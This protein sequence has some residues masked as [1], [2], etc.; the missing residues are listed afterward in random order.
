MLSALLTLHLIHSSLAQSVEHLTVNQGVAGSS[1]AGGAN[2]KHANRRAFFVGS[3]SCT[4]TLHPAR[5]KCANRGELCDRVANS[6]RKAFALSLVAW[7][8]SCFI[9]MCFSF[10]APIPDA[11]PTPPERPCGL[12]SH[13]AIPRGGGFIVVLLF[14]QPNGEFYDVKSPTVIFTFQYLS[15]II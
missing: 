8:E 14:F 6:R 1:P 10:L 12:S 13:L 2:G 9:L 15:G 4:R 5:P 3:P 11:P 7:F